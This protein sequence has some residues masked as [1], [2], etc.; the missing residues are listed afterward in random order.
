MDYSAVESDVLVIGGGAA[1]LRAAAEAARKGAR[2]LL[3]AKT[4]VS[5]AA[6]TTLA[7]GG[8]AG[9][10]GGTTMEKHL[11]VTKQDGRGLNDPRLLGVMVKRAPEF[12]HEL[13]AASDLAKVD[14]G[15]IR[16]AGPMRVWGLS[17]ALALEK[18]AKEAGAQARGHVVILDLLI[19]NGRV[20]G[21][22]GYDR[23]TGEFVLLGTGAV[24]L[25]TG[26]GGAAYLRTDN[27]SRTVGDGYALASRAG[28]AL[29]DMEFVQFFPLGAAETGRKAYMLPPALADEA[30]L[31]NSRGENILAKYGI[32]VKPAAVRCRD[33]LSIAM[34]R[35]AL[36]GNDVDGAMLLDTRDMTDEQWSSNPISSSMRGFLESRYGCRDRPIPTFPTCHFWMGGVVI[37]ESGATEIP[38]LYA[39]GEV[40]GG[41]HGANRMGGNALTETVV[42]GALAGA[43]AAAF[44]VG[45]PRPPLE[46][47]ELDA[48]R[49]WLEK[50]RT[51][52]LSADAAPSG[53]RHEVSRILWSHVGIVR[54][55]TGLNT[56]L[57]ALERLY[58]DALPRMAVRRPHEVME[59][60]E[61]EN[62]LEVAR[63]VATAAL[64]RRESRGA[65]YREDFPSPD[66]GRWLC[67]LFLRRRGE[68]VEIE[69]ISLNP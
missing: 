14:R 27:P 20:S 69:E 33:Q 54:N 35:E 30:R 50:L 16:F 45:S 51:R 32:D 48:R 43:S 29:R 6:A 68:S 66:D 67:S 13:I 47:S 31:V 57:E 46:S 62:L 38:G 42:Y 8:F 2:T 18:M 11:A 60:G 44:A 7:G 49:Q 41:V 61:A 10:V 55:E 1:G 64:R 36:M 5:R 40:T 26:G 23:K 21:A 37:D 65:H 9:S 3:V 19:R 63:M 4:A 15:R 53:I 59:A 12:L 17:V 39:A 58:R 56:A 22:L 24:V 25:A 28:A 52:P 34:F